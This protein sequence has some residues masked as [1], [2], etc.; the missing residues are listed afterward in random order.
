MHRNKV[1]WAVSDRDSVD[2]AAIGGLSAREEQVLSLAAA[3]FLDKQ[4]S[5]EL[6]VSLNTL[7]TY[8]TRI[9]AKIGEAPRSALAV[10][11]VERLT[12]EEGGP[13]W[14]VDL[15]RQTW[16]KVSNRVIAVDLP[17]RTEISLEVMLDHFH[18]DDRPGIR[19]LLDNLN[20]HNSET[21]TFSARIVAPSG[22]SRR[23]GGF[24]RIVRDQ[25]GK[26][27]KLFGRHS[28]MLDIR[29]SSPK[30]VGHNG[31]VYFPATG[32]VL[33]SDQISRLHGLEPGVPQP[34]SAFSKLFFADD[35][36]HALIVLDEI[37][38]GE[39]ETTTFTL[40]T[41]DS[42]GTEEILITAHGVRDA[43]GIVS[44]VVAYRTELRRFRPHAAQESRGVRVGFWAK[45]LR[46][47]AFIVP[48]EEFCKIYRVDRNSPSLDQDI[49]SR[50]AS[51]DAD[52]AYDFIEEAVAE[53]RDR[54]SKEFDLVFVDG[55]KQ[56]IKL[57]FFVERDETRP[58]RMNGTVLAFG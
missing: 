27:L 6:G 13:D 45:D 46:S 12:D 8:W 34:R 3:G 42:G 28:A 53:G 5:A 40:R 38:R 39:Y 57:E 18:V 35:Y 51:E 26:A 52:A 10:A 2:K 41:I 16:T 15:A 7:R 43:S 54:G 50:Y 22:E 47:G 4:I 21:F 24:V 55:S 30:A 36:D 9:R 14:E 33:A 44:K 23:G 49:R 20:N 58:V 37:A 29:D 19:S 48:D 32:M 25:E 1:E 31:W 17:A 56:R 11:Y